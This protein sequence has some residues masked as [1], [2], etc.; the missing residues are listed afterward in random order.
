M[1]NT[2]NV[3]NARLAEKLRNEYKNRG[4]SYASE[5]MRHA[6]A[7]RN[8]EGSAYGQR[9]RASDASRRMGD[10]A[11]GGGARNANRSRGESF[12]RN[13]RRAE[14]EAYRVHFAEQETWSEEES[15]REIRV[16]RKK[17]PAGF[18][19]VLT[20]C[21]LMIMLI[22]MSVA[23]IYQTTREI[24]VLEKNVVVLKETIDELE[25]KLDEKNDIRLIEQMATASLG[26]V[27][28]DSLQRKYISLSEGE[29]IDLIE[30]PAS[31]GD[32]STEGGLGTML[33]SILSAFGD[34]LEY[35]R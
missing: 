17:I 3:G 14:E 7:G 35:F 4:V 15:P 24:S 21:T 31:A 11:R 2:G 25:L 33:S 22:I 6:Q 34:L 28:E 1:G 9:G 29:H 10:E 23:Q 19:L 5:S 30:T 8:P 32:L 18:L 26:M 12:E 20:F 16:E 13:R 27:K